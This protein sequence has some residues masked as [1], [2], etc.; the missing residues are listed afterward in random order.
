MS[1]GTGSTLQAALDVPLD[2]GDREWIARIEAAR[3]DLE[4]I[5]ELVSMFATGAAPPADA[6]RSYTVA[7]VSRLASQQRTWAT[8]LYRLVRQLRPGRCVEMGTCLGVSAA[9]QAAALERNGAGQLVTIEGA[10]DRSR[11]A[12][13]TLAGLGLARV[14]L[15]VGRFNEVL[16]DVLAEEPAD[17]VFVDGHHDEEATLRYYDQLAAL[18]APRAVVVFDDITWSEG[19]KRAWQRI[20]QHPCTEEVLDLG[21][22]GVIRTLSPQARV[23]ASRLGSVEAEADRQIAELRS[24]IDRL[25]SRRA[26]QLADAVGRIGRRL[27]RR[28]IRRP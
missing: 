15:R 5:D 8:V 2:D 16:L 26:L 9:Y 1:T 4:S 18:V 12:A 7:E 6:D 21:K 20:I 25:R 13:R 24:T 27:L 17:L 28:T 3:A 23:V 11:I 14:D 10:A 22:L 19:M